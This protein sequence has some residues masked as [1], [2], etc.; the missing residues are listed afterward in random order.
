M[1]TYR[2]LGDF[3]F[4]VPN[5]Y[6]LVYFVLRTYIPFSKI[7][8]VLFATLSSESSARFL[9]LERTTFKSIEIISSRF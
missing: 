7:S 1:Q 9:V 6:F 8:T 3:F 2:L 4:P 5:Q